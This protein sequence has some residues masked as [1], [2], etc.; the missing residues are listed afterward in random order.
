M[1]ETLHRWAGWMRLEAGKSY[2]TRDRERV[3]R[4]ISLI[5]KWSK[6]H[7]AV[8]ELHILKGKKKIQDP[9]MFHVYEHWSLKGRYLDDGSDSDFDLIE[10]FLVK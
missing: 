5:G 10:E 7:P 8:G 4:I 9:G 3:A 6:K 2:L 1:A